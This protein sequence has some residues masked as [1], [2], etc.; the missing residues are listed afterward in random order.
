M[1][2]PTRA[3]RISGLVEGA[4]F[5][6]LVFIAM[7]LKYLAGLPQAVKVVGLLHGI[8]F[9]IFGLALLRTWA[10]ERWPFSRVVLVFIAALVPFGP[11]LIDRRMREWE[12]QGATT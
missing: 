9:V 7:P 12:A 1:T 3:L 6:L 8:L 2:N 4:S 10:A 11:F 5:L